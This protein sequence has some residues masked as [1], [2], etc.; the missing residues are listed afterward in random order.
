MHSWHTLHFHGQLSLTVDISIYSRE[1]TESKLLL[2]GICV[3]F[4]YFG[5]GQNELNLNIRP[6][7]FIKVVNFRLTYGTTSAT[8][9]HFWLEWFGCKFRSVVFNLAVLFGA[10]YFSLLISTAFA[11][12]YF[13][14]VFS[15]LLVILTLHSCM[16]HIHKAI[17]VPSAIF[18]THWLSWEI[19]LVLFK[20]HKRIKHFCLRGFSL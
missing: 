2:P 6:I 8:S 17:I 14:T 5:L 19:K 3:F 12:M 11:F 15:Q 10:S 18:L 20:I 7:T 4:T 16:L 9:S 1:F 13:E